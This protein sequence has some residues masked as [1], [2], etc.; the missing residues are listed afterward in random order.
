MP[1]GNRV[2]PCPNSTVSRRRFL[3]GTGTALGAASFASILPRGASA[4]VPLVW[5]TGSQ[6]DAVN[7]WVNMFK[8]RTGITCEFYR[9]GALKIAQKFEQEVAAK[10][11]SCSLISGGL[12][13]LIMQWADRGLLM[14]YDCPEYAHYPEDAL[15][16]NFAGPTKSDVITMIYN[17]ELI[18][19]EELPQSWEDILK[20]EWKGRMVMSDASSSSGALHW[21]SAMRKHFGRGYME[22]LAKQDVMIRTGSGEVVNT[23]ISGER[24]LAAMV[25]QYHALRAISKGAK[26]R[27]LVPKEGAPVSHAHLSIAADAANPEA[28][29]KFMDFAFGREAQV[30]WQQRYFTDSMRDDMPEAP[31][32]SGA[33]P[34]ATM[35]RI[36][37]TPADEIEYFN[38]N[39]EI[40]DEWVTLFKS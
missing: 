34:L 36:A 19:A 28:A 18:K 12:T 27:V 13:G 17:S 23:V 14:P 11:V 9:A 40:S 39:A 16:G 26:L 22:N 6:I 38:N 33:V 5:Y 31:R 3:Y 7:D 21:Y 8:E 2:F 15:I 37:S 4:D 35:T 30:A 24:P 10:Q 29:K 32:D 25:L 20:P 1:T